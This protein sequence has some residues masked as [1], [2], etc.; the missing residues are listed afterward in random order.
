MKRFDEIVQSN[1]QMINSLRNDDG[2][3][4]LMDVVFYDDVFDH[5]LNIS[6]DFSVVDE[7]GDNILHRIVCFFGGVSDYILSR[8]LMKLSQKTNV[9]S[10]INIKDRWGKTPLH[11]AA[12]NNNHRT[13][14]TIIKLGGDVNL[15]DGDGQT[16]LHRAAYNNLHR[17]IETM[18]K[19]GGDVNLKNNYNELP[20][21]QDR[22]DDETKRMIRS[23]RKW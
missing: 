2:D 19:L 1:P 15:K 6:Q 18:I 12:R 11:W 13:I 21:E 22:C 14:E 16:P 4:L 9:E 5:L 8:R 17:A 7:N 10:F 3:S 20:D 23:S